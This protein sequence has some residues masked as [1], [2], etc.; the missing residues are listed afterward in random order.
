MPMELLEE[1]A[2]VD[3]PFE[4]T[5]RADVEKLRVLL[6][7]GHVDAVIP[8]VT[9]DHSQNPAIVLEITPLGYKALRFFGSP[10]RMHNR[11]P[12]PLGTAYLIDP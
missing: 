3:L 4:I 6:A 1:L 11:G 5:D 10:A 12:A 7:A 9:H 8:P 2:D